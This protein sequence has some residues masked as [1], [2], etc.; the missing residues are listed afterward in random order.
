MKKK[1]KYG[2]DDDSRLDKYLADERMKCYFREDE[3]NYPTRITAKALALE[4]F[5]GGPPG[6]R[7]FVQH[8]DY[9]HTGLMFPNHIAKYTRY[10]TLC[11]LLKHLRRWVKANPLSGVSHTACW[12]ILSLC[13]DWPWVVQRLQQELSSKQDH[14][15]RLQ[16]LLLDTPW[17]HIETARALEQQMELQSKS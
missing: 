10:S 15:H 6:L 3:A 9:E 12:I 17:E 8:P 2:P 11:C 4:L 14:D 7:R 1:I 13:I 5:S 16:E